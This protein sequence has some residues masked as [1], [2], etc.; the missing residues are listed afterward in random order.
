VPPAGGPPPAYAPPAPVYRPRDPRKHGPILF[1][2]TLALVTLGLGIL[3][4]FDVAGS[5]VAPSAY[6][7]LATAII[8][9]MLL[10]GAFYGRAGGLILLGLIASV[11][12]VG[13]T[14][15]ENIDETPRTARP[16]TAGAV[17]DRYSHGAGEI[18]VDLTAIQNLEALDGRSITVESGAGR[19]EVIV[20]DNIDVLAEASLG[21]GNAEVFDETR[22]GAGIEV[23]TQHDAIDEVATINLDVQLGVGEIDVRTAAPVPA[24][25]E[26]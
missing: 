5:D 15:G 9:V 25:R 24:L 23:Q 3:G 4:M 19:I 14:I 16:I 10:V 21:A 7:A 2:F 13:S 8:A 11:G 12:L 1:W 18:V 17:P 22:D 20:P 26:N 6:P